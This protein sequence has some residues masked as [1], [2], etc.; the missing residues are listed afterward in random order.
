M[1]W[2]IIVPIIITIALILLLIY[3]KQL[4]YFS[5]DESIRN[6]ASLYN[7]A[8]MSITNM[9]VTDTLTSNKLNVTGATTTKGITNT[10]DISNTGNISQTGNA[11][12]SGNLY[13]GRLYTGGGKERQNTNWQTHLPF[14]DGNNYIRGN[15]NLDGELNVRDNMIVRDNLTVNGNLTVGGTIKVG[16]WTI[17]DVGN[18]FGIKDPTIA[19]GTNTTGF[20]I[21]NGRIFPLR[22]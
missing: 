18:Y 21:V 6:V 2:C 8:N 10:G 9:G 13:T 20:D 7:T 19:S 15:T 5:T 12:V 22:Q 1:N 17:G 16:R 14:E 3:K 4:E 11:N